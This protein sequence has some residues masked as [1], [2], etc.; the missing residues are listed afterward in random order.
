MG[1]DGAEGGV[2]ALSNGNYVVPSP[3]W[4]GSR[5]ARTWGNGSTGQTLDGRGII[6]PQDSLVGGAANAYF[7]PIRDHADFALQLRKL[8]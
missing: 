5:G 4:N 2:T 6:T 1:Y 7:D 3:Y 8:R